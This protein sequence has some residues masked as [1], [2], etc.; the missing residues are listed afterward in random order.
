MKLAHSIWH[1]VRGKA[2]NPKATTIADLASTVRPLR[3]IRITDSR[4]IAISGLKD[5]T[6]R[7]MSWFCNEW[8]AVLEPNTTEIVY[9]H[10]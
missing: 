3:P 8:T 10:H 1:C 6:E 4:A 9:D 7:T 2:E 5:N